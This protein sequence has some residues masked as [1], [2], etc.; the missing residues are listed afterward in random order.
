MYEAQ[1]STILPQREPKYTIS[2]TRGLFSRAD[3]NRLYLHHS[4]SLL[5]SAATCIDRHKVML[6]SKLFMLSKHCLMRRL[7]DLPFGALQQSAAWICPHLCV[8]FVLSTCSLTGQ[9]ADVF[10][11]SE[12]SRASL[13]SLSLTSNLCRMT[14]TLSWPK[15]ESLY[16]INFKELKSQLV[17]S[18]RNAM[19]H[20]YSRWGKTNQAYQFH[21]LPFRENDANQSV[22][23][24]ASFNR[25]FLKQVYERPYKRSAETV[26]GS[27][28]KM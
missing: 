11:S 1:P 5:F 27:D 4:V 12:S 2:I 26:W 7:T 13:L 28:L 17:L 25:I 22:V 14:G 15:T 21:L 9:N 19:P 10:Q 23:D 6:E 20:F 8:H 24:C 3:T 16:P 18:E